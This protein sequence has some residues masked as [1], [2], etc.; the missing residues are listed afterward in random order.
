[1]GRGRRSGA[2]RQGAEQGAG[3]GRVVPESS[4][5]DAAQHARAFHP[6]FE[7]AHCA[8]SRLRTGARGSVGSRSGEINE[9]QERTCRSEGKIRMTSTENASV[10]AA[11]KGAPT[12]EFDLVIL[13]GGTGS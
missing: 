11:R 2:E 9:G 7:R 10:G 13:G 3:I 1:M 5:S 8:R 6:A 12:E 4:G